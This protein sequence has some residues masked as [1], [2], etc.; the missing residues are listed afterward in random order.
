M[1]C[2]GAVLAARLA[3]QGTSE[4]VSATAKAA[5]ASTAAFAV[6]ATES[7][8]EAQA[9]AA[10][11]QQTIRRGPKLTLDGFDSSGKPQEAENEIKTMFYSSGEY[12]FIIKH[13]T[14]YWWSDYQ[15]IHSNFVPEVDGRVVQGEKPGRYGL[16]FRLVDN[17]N[18]YLYR[19]DNKACCRR[20]KLVKDESEMLIGWTHSPHIGTGDSVHRLSVVAR[21]QEV[22]LYV[23]GQ[24]L[25]TVADGLFE[26][27]ELGLAVVGGVGSYEDPPVE[28]AFDNLTVWSVGE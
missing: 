4:A 28:I 8:R 10:A 21:G 27:E 13:E 5:V 15:S 9:L 1:H 22:S 19:V 24:L 7:T 6:A 14:Y 12:R 18:Y 26:Q 11:E 2:R 16:V 25:E 23:N 20:S 17:D 3:V